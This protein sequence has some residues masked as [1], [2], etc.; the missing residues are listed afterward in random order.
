MMAIRISQLPFKDQLKFGLL[1]K[2]DQVD[3][4]NCKTPAEASAMLENKKETVH[5]N[6]GTYEPKLQVSGSSV[7]Y[8]TKNLMKKM[9]RN[10]WC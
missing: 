2:A 5:L 10:S 8:K 1:S 7:K 9:C 4:L 6:M 3:I